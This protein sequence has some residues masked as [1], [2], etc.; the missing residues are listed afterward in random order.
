MRADILNADCA[1]QGSF[2]RG[3]DARVKIVFAVSCLAMSA[4]SATPAVPLFAGGLSIALL[5]ASGVRF[6]QVALRSVEPLFFALVIGIFQLFLVPGD[7][8]FGTELFGISFTAT[9]EGLARG[10]AILTRVFGGVMVVLF[11][12]MT[13]PIDR[14]LGAAAWL[15]APKGFVEVT[16]FAYRYVFVLF[17]DAVTVYHAQRGRLGYGSVRRALGSLGML[18]GSVFLR[19]FDQAGATGEAMS[20]RGYSGS[21][22]PVCS[23]SRGASGAAFLAV[24]AIVTLSLFIWT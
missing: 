2:V 10:T 9:H 17:E 5:A 12:S 22:V 4:G 19:A 16:M 14:L 8:L 6:G 18:A 21:Y 11:V 13:T 24:L 3:M 1:R 15:K 20:L 23:E 7:A